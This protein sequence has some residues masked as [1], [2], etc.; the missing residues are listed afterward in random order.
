MKILEHKP[1][2]SNYNDYIFVVKNLGDTLIARIANGDNPVTIADEF[3]KRTTRGTTCHHCGSDN[4]EFPDLRCAVYDYYYY[5]NT[6]AWK[7]WMKKFRAM[8]S[9]E[10]IK[11]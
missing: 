6:E 8:I 11:N 2:T 1:S 10:N 4:L 5:V 3:I 7:L 9:V